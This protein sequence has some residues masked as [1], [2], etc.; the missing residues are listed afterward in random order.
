M[1]QAR[2]PRSNF[3]D[4]IILGAGAAGLMCAGVAGQ[5]GH[6]VLLLEQSRAPGREDPYL[7]RRAMQFHQSAH[8][9]GEFSVGQ[10]AVLHFG[11]ERLYPARFHRAGRELRYRLAR[12]DARATVLRRLV[13]ANHRHAAG[14]MPQGARATAPGCAYLRGLEG[15]RRLCRCHGSGR[16]SLPLAGGRHRRSLDS[17]NGIERLRIQNRRAIRSQDRAAARGA[18]ALDVR[19]RAAGAVCGSVGR[20]GRC[21]S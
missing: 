18:G 10:S 14:G 1:T 19:R 17:Q 12:E 11:A 6:Q 21:R 20:F 2:H 9:P 7:R 13:A 4:V 16:V 8:Q 3:H 5:R 15:R